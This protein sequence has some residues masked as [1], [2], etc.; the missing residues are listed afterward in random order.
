M[1]TSSTLHNDQRKVAIDRYLPRRRPEWYYWTKG[2][3]KS[4]GEKHQALLESLIQAP[5][6]PTNLSKRDDVKQTS[7]ESPLI[8]LECLLEA[9]TVHS[10]ISGVSSKPPGD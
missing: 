3:R 2:G 10:Y 4:H 1:P 9:L 6:E 7:D 5:H 8:F